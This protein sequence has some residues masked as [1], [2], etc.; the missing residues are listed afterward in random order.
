[1][2]LR[3]IYW[4]YTINDSRS[5][6]EVTSCSYKSVG[7]LW[8]DLHGL[9]TA[10][11]APLH[12]CFKDPNPES[13][14]SIIT[15]YTAMNCKFDEFSFRIL[16]QALSYAQTIKTL[17]FH[18]CELSDEC[19]TLLGQLFNN[20]TFET[21]HLDWNSGLQ[22]NTIIHLIRD[23]S[24]LKY[25]SL[26][27]CGIDE[28]CFRQI[29]G[30]L[31]TNRHL[32]GLDLYGNR[33]TSL[34]PLAEALEENRHLTSLNLAH[35]CLTDANIACLIPAIGRQP[36][37]SEQVDEHRKKEKERDI[38]ANKQAKLKIKA[39]EHVPIVDRIE[40]FP[41]GN[42]W[43]IYKNEIFSYL[44]ISLNNFESAENLRSVLERANQGFKLHVA[45][46]HIP[47][48]QRQELKLSYS[49][50]ILLT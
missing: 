10:L 28:E 3:F 50:K 48:M 25:L 49:D 22:Y 38:I 35:N 32:R 24:Q 21:L 37:P 12:P 47:K 40:H 23:E 31:K 15:S 18:N 30:K 34:I 4:H 45:A 6:S 11:N 9:C 41:D 33:V 44:N 42:Q 46:S 27:C 8:Q 13:S 20:E 17:K 26:R 2:E 14:S 36:F 16:V 1:M 29:C 39:P 7:N 19:I 5:P 43:V